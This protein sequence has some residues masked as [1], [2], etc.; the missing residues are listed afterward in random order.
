MNL[1]TFA[2]S[3]EGGIAVFPWMHGSNEGKG[4]RVLLYL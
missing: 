2:Q 1:D 4:D 3:L